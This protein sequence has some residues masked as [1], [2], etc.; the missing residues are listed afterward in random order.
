M[1]TYLITITLADG[2]RDRHYGRYSDGCSA[3]IAA[4]QEFPDA[5]RI[6]ARRQA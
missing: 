1:K 6:C 4:L 3:I 2:N 5:K